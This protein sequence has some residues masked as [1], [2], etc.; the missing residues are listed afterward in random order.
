M[1]VSYTKERA[2]FL[3]P[4]VVAAARQRVEAHLLPLGGHAAQ[5]AARRE[6]AV[7]RRGSAAPLVP[8]MGLV[9]AKLQDTVQ[10]ELARMASAPSR[11]GGGGRRGAGGGARDGGGGA[12]GGAGGGGGGD[13]GRRGQGGGGGRPGG[14]QA[15]GVVGRRRVAEASGVR[16]VGG[17][18]AAIAPFVRKLYD[19]VSA[20]NECIRWAQDGTSF[21]IGAPDALES[22]VLPR[23]FKHNR[24]A[25][26][27]KQLKAY[28]FCAKRGASCLD[29][30]KEWFH[31][32]R[33]TSLPRNSAQFR[34]IPRNSAQFLQ[35]PLSDAPLPPSLSPQAGAF[36]RGGEESLVNIQRTSPSRSL[37][38]NTAGSGNSAEGA[39]LAAQSESPP[40]T[41]ATAAAAA[42]LPGGSSSSGLRARAA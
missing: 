6:P 18:G 11:G 27:V 9:Y 15:R 41:T 17:V 30:S 19:M 28:G 25:F 36:Y 31:K 26:F 3:K 33:A 13:R 34:A 21:W 24:M 12:R 16:V 29:V 38:A 23:F 14:R 5:P 35:H 20:G 1:L 39:A 7:R 4:L 8:G 10:Q 2:P 22:T 40:V 37:A 42:A 32:V